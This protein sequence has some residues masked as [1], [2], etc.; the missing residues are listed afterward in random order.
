MNVDLNATPGADGGTM[1]TDCERA[2]LSRRGF[3][4]GA[5]GL[6]A[7]G[8]VSGFG[9]FGS[10]QLA[11]ADS[12]YD[13]DV[14]VVVSLRGGFD[15]LSAVVP[16]GDPNYAPN[17]PSIG[18]PSSQLFTLDSMFGMNQAL[19]PL[20]PFWNAGQLAFVHA[21]GQKDPTMSHFEAMEEME[22][23]A[24]GSSVRTGWI[25]RMAGVTGTGTPFAATSVGPATAPSSMSGSYPVTAMQSLS[26]FSLSGASSQDVASW[27]TALRKLQHGAPSTI[28]DPAV[29]TL[30]ALKT[31]QSLSAQKYTP[32]NGATYPNDDVGGSLSSVAQLIKAGVGL[33]VAAVDCGNWDMHVGM[34]TPTNGWMYS[35]LTG[36]GQAL[37][38]FAT[39]LGS[40]FANVA[41]VTLSEFGRRVMENDSQ[42]LDHG[43]G[44]AVFVLG[45]GVKG[46]AVYGRWPGLANDDLVLGNLKG[47]TDYRTIL[48][49]LL[50]KRCG[51]STTRVFPGL[52]STRLGL[53]NART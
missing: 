27:H 7:L 39:D 38:A 13:G 8:M 33:R 16:A 23:A 17:R 6:A 51:L 43:H 2:R 18:V 48:A 44:N 49:E 30:A 11:F 3:L 41:V 52:G 4:G 34:G 31:T 46:G 14:L 25:D 24:P 36:L 37:A 19:A 47:A 20:I 10:T 12:S 45:G 32:A 53:A 21:V 29:T 9:P 1:C 42:G 40:A 26:S 50:E 22:R 5:A 28:A 35:N 15:G